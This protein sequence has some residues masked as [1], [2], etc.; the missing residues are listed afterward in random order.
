MFENRPVMMNYSTNSD[1]MEV[2]TSS[3]SL[4]RR[5]PEYDMN[6][7]ELVVPLKRRNVYSDGEVNPKAIT[8]YLKR[9]IIDKGYKLNVFSVDDEIELE[10]PKSNPEPILNK[11]PVNDRNSIDGKPPVFDFETPEIAGSRP[12]FHEGS[13]PSFNHD[14]SVTQP[15]PFSS[16]TPNDK[17]AAPIGSGGSKEVQSLLSAKKQFRLR[18]A[19]L[20]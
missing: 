8:G 3:Q 16:S 19:L 17:E 2:Q 11:N 5:N 14:V 4:K 20:Q 15:L 7:K 13:L 12:P 10:E 6:L 18:L 9:R 1:Q